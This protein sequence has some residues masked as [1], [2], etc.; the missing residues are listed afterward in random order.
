MDKK[1]EYFMDLE[2][3]YKEKFGS[4]PKYDFNPESTEDAMSDVLWSAIQNDKPIDENSME[5]LGAMYHNVNGEM[6]PGWFPIPDTKHNREILTKC[7]KEK[8]IY[9]PKDERDVLY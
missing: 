9:H 4:L 1:S 5:W 2:E 7:I 3:E 8:M 6:F